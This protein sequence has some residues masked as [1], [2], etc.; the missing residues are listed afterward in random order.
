MSTDSGPI[1]LKVPALLSG[2]RLDRAVS[3][4]TGLSRSAA[5]E[6]ISSGGVLLN[7]NE[8]RTGKLALVRGTALEIRVGKARSRAVEPDGTVVFEVVYED[9]QIIVV[10]KPAGLVVHP[11]AGHRVGTMVS[12]LLARYPE[13]S[14]LQ[15]SGLCDRDRPGIVHRLDRGTSGLVV[16]ARTNDAYRS[17]VAQ[18]S[19]HAVR[20]EY[21]TLVSGHLE[22]DRGVIDA[23]IGRSQRHPTK[24]A[25]VA[26]GKAAITR[27][28][29]EARYSRPIEATLL[30][31]EL[32][33]GRTHQIRVHLAAIDHPVL[34]DDRYGTRS[35]PFD[36]M[37]LHA[38]RLELRHPRTDVLMS[39]TAPLPG[40]L[41][42]VIEVFS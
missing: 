33:T 6:L 10:D 34:G 25:V 19:T 20:R 28:R 22:S 26:D 9:D 40:E 17:L 24:M 1:S 42:S 32:E 35:E 38:R 39:W 29:V 27:Y 36:T 37:F 21:T 31:V 11:G 3:L 7:G 18:L 8:A 5:T 13:L 4:L 14:R 15:E 12:G 16:V 23:P 41:A 30:D 2:V